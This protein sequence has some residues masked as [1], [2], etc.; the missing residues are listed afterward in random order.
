MSLQQHY[1]VRK[2]HLS[3]AELCEVASGQFLQPVEVTAGGRPSS[4]NILTSPTV[5]ISYGLFFIFSWD[6]LESTFPPGMCAVG[7]QGS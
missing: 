6:G 3:C 7:W 5:D 2:D 1:M 4:Q